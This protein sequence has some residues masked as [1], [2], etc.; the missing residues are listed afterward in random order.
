MHNPNCTGNQIRIF[1]IVVELLNRNIYLI[2][3]AILRKNPNSELYNLLIRIENLLL[4]FLYCSLSIDISF[5]SQVEESLKK[6]YHYKLIHSRA[7]S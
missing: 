3:L 2:E 5:K 7:R 4:Y 6:V 1:N